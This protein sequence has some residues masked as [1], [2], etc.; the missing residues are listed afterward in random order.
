M[1]RH[2]L[3]VLLAASTVPASLAWSGD[4]SAQQAPGLGDEVKLKDGSVFRGTITELVPHDHID[5]LLPGGKTRRFAAADVS[6]A[7]P[8]ARPSSP[9]PP[10]GPPGP[11]T[12]NVRVESDQEDVQLFVRAGQIEGVGWGYHGAIGLV[13]RDYAALCTAPCE[14]QMPI[15]PQ[16]LA[17]SHHGGQVVEAED[18]VSVGGP[19]TLRVHYDSRLGVR[20]AGYII[21]VAAA[22]TGIV[23]I[24]T[25]YNGNCNSAATHCQ[26]FNTGQLIAGG[27]V[28]IGGAVV[29][30]I[31][32]SIGD[33]ANRQLV[34]MGAAGPIKLPGANESAAVAP[35]E[36]AGLALQLSF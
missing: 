26:Q 6:Y 16:R 33:K 7:G 30:G 12:A 22:I 15:G 1:K 3:A 23:L 36:G 34:P 14:T 29:G 19:A 8:A 32:S 2:L 25:S 17:L 24:A 11:P 35:R 13:A 28:L 31:L 10:A 5:L 4:A 18:P 9:P 27:V 20:V 21:G